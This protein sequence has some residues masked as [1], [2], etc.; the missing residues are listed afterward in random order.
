MAQVYTIQL[1]YSFIDQ[2]GCFFFTHLLWKREAIPCENLIYL[3]RCASISCFQVVTEWVSEW[4]SNTYFFRS[5][6]CTVFTVSAVS[7]VSTVYTISTVSTVSSV[8]SVSSVSTIST[9]YTVYT[10][11]TVFTV[12]TVSTSKP[13][14]SSGRFSSIFYFYITTFK[15]EDWMLRYL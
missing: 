11:Y 13:S 5:S 10:V 6:V 2:N 12:S 8:S 14:A 15:T 7:F 3:F 4:V 9:V 1:P